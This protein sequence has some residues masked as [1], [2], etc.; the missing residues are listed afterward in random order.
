[1]RIEIELSEFFIVRKGV[2][3][4][5]LVSPSLFN[6]HSENIFK[7][8]LDESKDGII[9]NSQI[10][11]ILTTLDMQTTTYYWQIEHRVFRE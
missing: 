1:M 6:I 10:V 7:K 5:C 3:L 9:V 8:A 2:R 4:G 11:N